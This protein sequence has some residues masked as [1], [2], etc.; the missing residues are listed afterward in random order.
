MELTLKYTEAFGD[1]SRLE[2][3]MIWFHERVLVNVVDEEILSV[4]DP[5][6]A[7]DLFLRKYYERL[8]SH[9]KVVPCGIVCCDGRLVPGRFMEAPEG[10]ISFGRNCRRTKTGSFINI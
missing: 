10:G 2:N 6:D 7:V 4:N 5:N 3:L 1:D 9:V 8:C